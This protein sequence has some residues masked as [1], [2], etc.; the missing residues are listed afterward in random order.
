[1]LLT[2]TSSVAHWSSLVTD[3]TV[4]SHLPD[5]YIDPD[6]TSN[7]KKLLEIFYSACLSEG[8]TTDE[9][10]LRGLRAVLAHAQ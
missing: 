1:M 4:T 8:G 3:K 5:N 10:T 9:I 6:L 2:K 7:D